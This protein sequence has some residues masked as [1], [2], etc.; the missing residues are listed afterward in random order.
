MNQRSG[1]DH[2]GMKATQEM[3]LVLAFIIEEPLCYPPPDLGNFKGVRK[4]VVKDNAFGRRN[5]LGYVSE[6]SPSGGVQYAVP[7]SLKRVPIV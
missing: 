2:I 5:D 3:S 6:T 1:F 7:V 4:T